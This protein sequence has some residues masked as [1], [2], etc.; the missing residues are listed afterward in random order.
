MSN[1]STVPFIRDICNGISDSLTY[2][3]VQN[4]LEYSYEWCVVLER[5]Y[6]KNKLMNEQ[7]ICHFTQEIF[8]Y[9]HFFDG[10]QVCFYFDIPKIMT[11]SN[12]LTPENFQLSDFQPLNRGA[13]IGYYPCTDIDL[14]YKWRKEPII[15]VP[16]FFVKGTSFLVVDGNHRISQAKKMGRSHIWGKLIPPMQAKDSIIGCFEKALYCLMAETN[17]V[18]QLYAKKSIPIESS[19]LTI[20]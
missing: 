1:S 8:L 14:T 5:L 20:F 7:D 17:L 6:K 16:F 18:V 4:A 11:V 15:T 10:I 9:D 19:L 2:G 13:L 3:K 12:N